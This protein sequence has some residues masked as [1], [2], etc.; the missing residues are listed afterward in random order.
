MCKDWL[1]KK[2]DYDILFQ[3]LTKGCEKRFKL[4]LCDTMAE[5]HHC[6]GEHDIDLN[7]VRELFGMENYIYIPIGVVFLNTNGHFKVI[8]VY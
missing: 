2:I 7:T 6:K 3:C 4:D 1:G 5:F 8:V